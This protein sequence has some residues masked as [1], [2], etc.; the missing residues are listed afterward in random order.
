MSIATGWRALVVAGFIC[1][2]P[3]A[4]S[5]QSFGIRAGASG[6][7][8]QFYIGAHMVSGPVADRVL[9]RPNIELGFGD[10]LT[11]LALNMEFVYTYP[12]RR[13]PWSVIAGG[14][15]AANVFVYDTGPGRGRDSE[16]R[17][18]VNGLVGLTHRDGFFVEVKLGFIDSPAVKLGVGFTF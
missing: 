7:P 8:D 16:L 15:P 3:A 18:G 12:F 1:A 14:G 5:A 17:G 10:H 2:L 6:D 9:V 11:L 4:A 13:S